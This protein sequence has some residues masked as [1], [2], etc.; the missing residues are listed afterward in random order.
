MRGRGRVNGDDRRHRRASPRPNRNH[1]P[2]RVSPRHR[3]TTAGSPHRSYAPPRSTKGFA[4]LIGIPASERR[5]RTNATEPNGSMTEPNS[6]VTRSRCGAMRSNSAPTGP[7]FV[8]LPPNGA[9]GFLTNSTLDLPHR[10]ENPERPFGSRIAMPDPSRSRESPRFP[11]GSRTAIPGP[12]H[13]RENPG[14]SPGSRTE[15]LSRLPTGSRLRGS[16]SR[17][18]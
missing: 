9:T 5:E 17:P 3:R 8:A 12:W 6:G 2:P 7:G 11:S 14:S 15:T 10:R 16:P 13:H 18:V 4:A 1:R